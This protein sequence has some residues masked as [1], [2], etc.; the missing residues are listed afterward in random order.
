MNQPLTLEQAETGMTGSP[1]PNH[2][3]PYPGDASTTETGPT[4]TFNNLFTQDQSQ[5]Q[6][7][8]T[9]V[10]TPTVPQPQ[11]T[12]GLYRDFKSV[13]EVIRY[14]QGLE[15]KLLSQPVDRPVQQTTQQTMPLATEQTSQEVRPGDIFWEDPNKAF[16][17]AVRKAVDVAVGQIESRTSKIDAQK[18]FWTDFYTSNPDLKGFEDD[19]NMIM[20]KFGGDLAPLPPSVGM[21]NLAEKTRAKLQATVSRLVKGNPLPSGGAVTMQASNTTPTP[22]M[23]PEVPVVSFVDQINNARKRKA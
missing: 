3:E 14:A 18:Q 17:I 5:Q 12:G 7:Q 11:T 8:S 22:K 21:K 10:Q 6:T 15:A 20:N 19:V 23:E 4:G 13:D 9:H 2:G 1:I 16:D